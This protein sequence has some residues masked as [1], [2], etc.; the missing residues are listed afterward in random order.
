MQISI[1]AKQD[2]C[3]RNYSFLSKGS[4]IHDRAPRDFP[5][6]L[7]PG[8]AIP[9]DGQEAGDAE[10]VAYFRSGT[11]MERGPSP[12]RKLDCGFAGE[13]LPARAKGAPPKVLSRGS[14]P[15]RGRKRRG[16]FPVCEPLKYH[17]TARQ[18]RAGAA[19]KHLGLETRNDR[20][21]VT[22]SPLARHTANAA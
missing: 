7:E 17:K 2:T 16:N 11:E 20:R 13:P 15:M 5:F 8:R 22:E 3:Y 9:V 18:S 6:G 12:S 21:R 10:R 1:P 19:T 14:R 4:R